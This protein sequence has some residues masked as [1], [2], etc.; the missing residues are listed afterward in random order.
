MGD[1][2]NMLFPAAFTAIVSMAALNFLVAPN[3][4]FASL[5]STQILTQGGIVFVAYII[6]GYLGPPVRAELDAVF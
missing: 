2:T 4:T 1:M 6:S 5:F 3:G